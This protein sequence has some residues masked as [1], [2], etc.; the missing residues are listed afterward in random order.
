MNKREDDGSRERKL[1][2][3]MAVGVWWQ[4]GKPQVNFSEK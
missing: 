2:M 4:E 3:K 1:S